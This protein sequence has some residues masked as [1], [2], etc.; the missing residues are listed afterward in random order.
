MSVSVSDTLLFPN[1]IFSACLVLMACIFLMVGFKGNQPAAELMQLIVSCSCHGKH[2][3]ILA[4]KVAVSLVLL[5]MDRLGDGAVAGQ[6]SHGITKKILTIFLFGLPL[7]L[8]VCQLA[9]MLFV[10]VI[11][12]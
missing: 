10:S 12:E 11:F 9:E 2:T 7:S 1:C 8:Y 3:V 4:G 5:C 6:E